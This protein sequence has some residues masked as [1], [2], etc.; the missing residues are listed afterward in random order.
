[1]RDVYFIGDQLLELCATPKEHLLE[2]RELGLGSTCFLFCKREAAYEYSFSL[3][4]LD[5]FDLHRE[6]GVAFG[7]RLFNP[8]ANLVIDRILE[9]PASKNDRQDGKAAEEQTVFKNR[10]AGVDQAGKNGANP[11]A[12]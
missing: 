10:P 11:F 2:I 7:N 6:V 3:D 1:M 12:V 5:T 4:A 9:I 8:V